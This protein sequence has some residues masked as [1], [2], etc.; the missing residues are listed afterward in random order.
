MLVARTE[1]TYGGGEGK[2]VMG[3]A[4]GPEKKGRGLLEVQE[5]ESGEENGMEEKE[6]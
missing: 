6:R 1:D 2:E 3:E 5:R 4:R